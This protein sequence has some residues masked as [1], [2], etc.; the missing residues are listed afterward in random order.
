MNRHHILDVL[1]GV[2]IGFIQAVLVSALWLS[3]ESAA[4]VVNFFLDETQVGA[5]YDV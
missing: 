3:E 1:G 5:S 4:G 2:A